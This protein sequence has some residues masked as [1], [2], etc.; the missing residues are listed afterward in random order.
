MQAM[1]GLSPRRLAPYG[2]AQAL[3]TCLVAPFSGGLV[4][5]HTVATVNTFHQLLSSVYPTQV[6]HSTAASAKKNTL[7]VSCSATHGIL[8]W[9]CPFFGW[10]FELGCDVG[11]GVETNR[12]GDK[13]NQAGKTG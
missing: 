3:C 7:A 2:D 13:S 11:S 8:F 5:V 9:L 12:Q 1:Q 10:Y 4:M 6:V